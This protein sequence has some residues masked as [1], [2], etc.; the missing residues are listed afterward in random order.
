MRLSWVQFIRYARERGVVVQEL[1]HRSPKYEMWHIND[2]SEVHNVDTL[3]EAAESLH[4]LI[5]KNG[6]VNA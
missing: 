5:Q 3:T 6:A 1:Y 2:C 4:E